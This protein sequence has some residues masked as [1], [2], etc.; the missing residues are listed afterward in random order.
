[1]TNPYNPILNYICHFNLVTQPPKLRQSLFLPLILFF[2]FPPSPLPPPQ[3]FKLSQLL[4]SI[5]RILIHIYR[6]LYIWFRVLTLPPP[7]TLFR[8]PPHHGPSHSLP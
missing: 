1:M 8:S 2:F 7:Y 4:H 6:L 3:T 5:Y